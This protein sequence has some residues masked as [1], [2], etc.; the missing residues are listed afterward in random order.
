MD[1]IRLVPVQDLCSPELQLYAERKEVQLKRFYEPEAGLFIAESKQVILRA[2]DAGYVPVS[3]LIQKQYAEEMEEILQ[4]VKVLQESSPP[5]AVYTASLDVMKEITGYNLT[6]GFLSLMRR[7]SLP[8]P[9]SILKNAKR[10][11]IL[12]RVTNPTNIGAIF[13][14]AAALGMD[15]I[16]LTS[17]CS[18]PLYRRTIRVS[19]GTVFQIPW[20]ILPAQHKI[21]PGCQKPDKEHPWTDTYLYPPYW[22]GYGMEALHDHGFTAVSMALTDMAVPIDSVLFKDMDKLALIL[23]NE[24]YGVS[25]E[26]LLLSDHQAVIPM[27][28]GVD[29][30]NVAAASAVAFWQLRLT[31]PHGAL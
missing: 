26:T 10:I 31:Q 8:P 24:A 7:R 29:S 6:Y 17:D 14:S 9:W 27:S 15:G 1:R 21:L 30:L 5:F 28:N 19:L 18:D 12:E 4:H 2:L 3:F 20:T 22:P 11:A 23:G 16:L 13:R 25:E